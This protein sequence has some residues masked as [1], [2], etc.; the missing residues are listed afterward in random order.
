MPHHRRARASASF[1]HPMCLLKYTLTNPTHLARDART[2]RLT[3]TWGL[4]PSLSPLAM[5]PLQLLPNPRGSPTPTQPVRPH[6]QRAL[7]KWMTSTPP[8]THPRRPYSTKPSVAEKVL[9]SLGGERTTRSPPSP[10]PRL[11]PTRAPVPRWREGFG[12]PRWREGD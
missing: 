2:S 7:R 3:Q 5:A 10:P 8:L 6:A 4:H 11:D 1:A 9:A 12:V